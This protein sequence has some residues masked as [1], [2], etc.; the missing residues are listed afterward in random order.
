[1][2]RCVIFCAG[3]EGPMDF[4]FEP[5]DFYI[6]CDAGLSAAQKLGVTP[7]LLV[8]DFDSLGCAPP[9]DLPVL[10]FPV[11]KDDTDSMLAVR[12]GLRRGFRRFALLFSLGGRLDHTVANIQTLAFLLERRAEG[13]LIGPSDTA[14]LLHNGGTAIARREGFTLSVFA[15]GGPAK[16]VTLTGV[17]YPLADAAVDTSF[18]IGVGNHIVAASAGV[19][20]AEGTL[21]LI[22][23]RIN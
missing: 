19:S 13:I 2:K 11:E 21:L 8:G 18:P 16:G 17:Q 10:R 5:D 23:S 22:E 15:F 20:V 3:E 9:C 14:R 1:M 12:E 6:C 7:H 4:S